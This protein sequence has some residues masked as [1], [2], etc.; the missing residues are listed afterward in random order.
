MTDSELK[1][2]LD[3]VR[4]GDMTAFEEIYNDLKIPIMTL[5]VRMTGDPHTAEDI[6]QEV[7][8]KLYRSPPDPTIAKPRAYIFRMA[9]NLAID[10]IRRR[11]RQNE[12][13][14]EETEDVLSC[15]GPDLEEKM[16]VEAA[17]S[18]LPDAERSIVT[19]HVNG[20]LKFREIAQVTGLPSGTVLW[21]Y[22]RAL[23]RLRTFLEIK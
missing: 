1:L 23:K 3:A 7:F 5:A 18:A 16:D 6:F 2:R 14:L 20:G 8:I 21:K 19:L 13:P 15:K 12:I 10:G 9:S 22:R 11:Q 17:L 4:A